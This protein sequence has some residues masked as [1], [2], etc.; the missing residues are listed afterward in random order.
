MLRHP[1]EIDSLPRINGVNISAADGAIIEG[2]ILD[3]EGSRPIVH[4][5]SKGV[6]SFNNL[7]SSGQNLKHYDWNHDRNIE[8]LREMIEAVYLL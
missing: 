6:H 4:S 3:A 7:D 1:P 8:Q 5:F 2:N